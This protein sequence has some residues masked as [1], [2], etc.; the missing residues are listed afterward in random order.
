MKS[1][2]QFRRFSENRI[3]AIDEKGRWPPV[4]R[5]FRRDCLRVSRDVG[6]KKVAEIF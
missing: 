6:E 3:A 1:E 4:K 5:Y 2:K